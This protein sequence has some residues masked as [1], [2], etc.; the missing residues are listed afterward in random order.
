MKNVSL[1]LQWNKSFRLEAAVWFWL[2]LSPIILN[3]QPLRMPINFVHVQQI[4]CQFCDI[5]GI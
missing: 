1:L 5:Y 4:F 2:D 3:Q